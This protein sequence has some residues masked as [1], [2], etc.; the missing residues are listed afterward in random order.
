[1]FDPYDQVR[2]RTQRL[3]ASGARIREERAMQATHHRAADPPPIR[4]AGA[5]GVIIAT[6]AAK[7]SEACPPGSTRRHAA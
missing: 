2:M 5:P 7:T 1:M 3:L 4:S 6:R